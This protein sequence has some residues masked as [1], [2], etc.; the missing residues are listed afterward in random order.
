M[1]KT[2]EL[3]YLVQLQSSALD[4]RLSEGDDRDPIRLE[5]EQRIAKLLG[6]EPVVIDGREQNARER[7]SKSNKQYH[8]KY[9]ENRV[10]VN[11]KWV[12]R[13]DAVQVPRANG[14]GWKWALKE[15]AAQEP[16]EDEH[17]CLSY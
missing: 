11:N 16:P 7:K 6:E 8:D 17:Q 5:V 3:K 14:V 2:E 1:N 13:E 9:K 12:L 15:E 4:W 10:R